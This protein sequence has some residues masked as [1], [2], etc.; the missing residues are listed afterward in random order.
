MLPNLANQNYNESLHAITY[1]DNKIY[2]CFTKV[3][4]YLIISCA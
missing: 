3:Y 4:Y 2:V 1:L